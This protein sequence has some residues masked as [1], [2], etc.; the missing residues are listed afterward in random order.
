MRVLTQRLP[1]EVLQALVVRPVLQGASVTL[2]G[3]MVPMATMMLMA[4]RLSAMMMMV[5]MV[6]T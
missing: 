3:L 5:A 4:R 1:L 2:V 6:E